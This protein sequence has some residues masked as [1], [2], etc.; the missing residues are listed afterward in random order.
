MMLDGELLSPLNSLK[1]EQKSFFFLKEL[2]E[3]TTYS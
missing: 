2:V 3:K 1:T